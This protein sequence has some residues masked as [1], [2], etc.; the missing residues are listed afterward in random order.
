MKTKVE[1][2]LYESQAHNN[3]LCK[4]IKRLEQEIAEQKN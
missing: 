2:D 3:Q 1:K 4:Q